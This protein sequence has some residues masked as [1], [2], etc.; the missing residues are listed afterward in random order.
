MAYILSL[1]VF[2]A[3]TGMIAGKIAEKKGY[4]FWPWFAIGFFLNLIAII[5][6]LVRND[7]Q[8]A[9]FGAAEEIGKYKRLLDDGAITQREYDQIKTELLDARKPRKNRVPAG[10]SVRKEKREP[11][12]RVGWLNLARIRGALLAVV[13]L[14]GVAQIVLSVAT[15]ASINWFGFL[16]S[17]YIDYFLAPEDVAIILFAL[18]TVFASL[19]AWMASSYAS[20]KSSRNLRWC[21]AFIVLSISLGVAAL[22]PYVSSINGAGV[23]EHVVGTD[24]VAFLFAVSC[25]LA[26]V[27]FMLMDKDEGAKRN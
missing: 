12:K 5:I 2:G 15:L 20:T 8:P 21:R 22:I 13:M 7:A 17:F 26:L 16:S 18:G 25:A 24:H 1:T 9:T 27:A 11:S 4:D 14:L 10:F 3:I 19:M 23:I 6:I